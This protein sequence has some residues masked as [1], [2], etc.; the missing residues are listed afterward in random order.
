[1]SQD[2]EGDLELG[3]ILGEILGNVSGRTE[4]CPEG[5]LVGAVLC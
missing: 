3:E 5:S 2:S 4:K 1:M